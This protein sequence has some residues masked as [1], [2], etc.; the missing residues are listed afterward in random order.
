[1]NPQSAEPSQN[2][3]RHRNKI[4]IPEIQHSTFKIVFN[5]PSPTGTQPSPSATT[6]HQLL[7]TRLSGSAAI[8]H[9]PS[10]IHHPSQSNIQHR[11][12]YTIPNRNADVPIGPQYPKSKIQN[13]SSGD[14]VAC[15]SINRA[16]GLERRAIIL[17]GL[18]AWEEC[19]KN[20][21]Q[22]RTFV[23]GA[24]R[25]QQLLAVLQ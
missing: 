6:R 2:P 4:Q 11:L 19:A 13:S 15:Y 9:S 8:H 25:A 20:D 17:T 16:K 12:Q 23:L 3:I 7:V 21:Y 18:P 5:P 1:M 10:K 14:S 24:T 22:S